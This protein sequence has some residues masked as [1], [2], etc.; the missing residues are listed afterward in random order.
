MAFHMD[1]LKDK[2]RSILDSSKPSPDLKAWPANQWVPIEATAARA[3]AM[4]VPTTSTTPDSAAPFAKW[5]DQ[6][7]SPELNNG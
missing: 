6:Y 1:A 3:S 5:S 4:F 7:F 2:Y